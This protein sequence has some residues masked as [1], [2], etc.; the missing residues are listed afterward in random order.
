MNAKQILLGFLPWIAFS[1]IS[2]RVGP[3]AV[4]AAALVALVRAAILVARTIARGQSVKLIEATA[5][6]TFAA[7]GVW[8][9]VSRPRT[10]S[11]PSTAAAWPR[12]SWPW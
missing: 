5:V 12:W 1:A 7:M 2:T 6:A 9:L 11:W 10:T 8:A 3:G 4:G